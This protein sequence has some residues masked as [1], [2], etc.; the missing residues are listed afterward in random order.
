LL[1]GIGG[2]VEGSPV[3]GRGHR[4]VLSVFERIG[5]RAMPLSYAAGLLKT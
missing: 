4:G 5:L 1:V 2:P 3:G